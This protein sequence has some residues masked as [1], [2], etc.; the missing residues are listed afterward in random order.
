ML[1][2]ALLICI[3]LYYVLF[4]IFIN[5]LPQSFINVNTSSTPL[6]QHEL[7][8]G[9]RLAGFLASL[10]PL[11][12]L[13]YVVSRIRRLFSYYKDGRIF[14]F[15]HVD[16]FK[17]IARG[18]L[19]WIVSSMVYESAKSIIFSFNN[20]PGHRVVTVGFSSAEI[21]TLLTGIMVLIIAWVMDEGRLLNEEKELTI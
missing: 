20:P 8:P 17:R 18:L 1:F 11:S 3:P 6:V 13:F 4:W 14:S 15:G 10:L 9:L 2:T 7:S 5:E 19:L 21:T 16:L 12:V